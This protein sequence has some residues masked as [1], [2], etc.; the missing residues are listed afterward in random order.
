MATSV[1]FCNTNRYHVTYNSEEYSQYINISMCLH[2]EQ[3]PCCVWQ[4]RIFT[5]LQQHYVSA[6]RTDTML[7]MAVENIHQMA[8][9]VCVCITNSY[10]VTYDSVWNTYLFSALKVCYWTE[11]LKLFFA[12]CNIFYLRTITSVWHNV[13]QWI[14]VLT[15]T[16]RSVSETWSLS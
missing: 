9:S 8:T 1:C 11:Y 2:Y 16:E 3:L 13:Y 4:W 10:H 5:R 7:R 15:V 12:V 14:T 6:F